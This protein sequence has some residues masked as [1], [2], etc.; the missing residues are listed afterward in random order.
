MASETR[1]PK[2]A[3]LVKGRPAGHIRARPRRMTVAPRVG[4]KT[5]PVRHASHLGGVPAGGAAPMSHTLGDGVIAAALDEIYV[6]DAETLRFVEVSAGAQN[7]LGYG[8]DD[9]RWM[10]PVHIKPMGRD[11]FETMIAP[12]RA[13]ARE[14]LQFET[15]HQRKDGSRYPVQVRLQLV[16]GGERPLFLAVV[17]DL[18]E[19]Q[20]LD[21]LLRGEQQVLE[22]MARNAKANDLLAV[23]IGGIERH[24]PRVRCSVLLLDHEGGRAH[25]VGPRMPAPLVAALNEMDLA[26]RAS[27]C[28]EAVFE[29]GPV[30]VG[31]VA[32]ETRWPVWQQ[33]ARAVGM[34]ACWSVPILAGSD[35]VVGAFS[36]YLEVRAQASR[37]Q[38]GLL[39]RAAHLAAI[40]LEREKAE[41]RMAYLSHFDDLT[42]LPNRALLQERVAKA[43]VHARRYPRNAAVLFI[44]L[45][46]WAQMSSFGSAVEEQALQHAAQ[47]LAAVTRETDTAARV[48]AHVFG[49]L[50]TDLE[51]TPAVL[52]ACHRIADSLMTPLTIGSLEVVLSPRIGIGLYPQDADTPSDLLQ[53]AGVALQQSQAQGGAECQFYRQATNEWVQQR[54]ALEA[55]LRK[56]LLRQELYLE[57]QPKVALASGRISGVEALLRWRHPTRGLVAPAEFIPVAEDSGL[58]VPIGAWVLEAACRQSQRWRAAGLRPLGMAVNLSGRQFGDPDLVWLVKRVLTE[59][60]LD[61]GSLELE[62]TESILMDRVEDNAATLRDIKQ[63]GVRLALDDFGTGY[64]S[65]SHLS[66][67]PVDRLKIDRAFVQNMAQGTGQGAI[68]TAIITMAH[69]L[70]LVVTAEGV[71]TEAQR[72]LLRAQGCDEIQGYLLSRALGPDDCEALLRAHDRAGAESAGT[73]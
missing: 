12:L 37:E 69:A 36:L 3:E 53:C 33:A 35:H 7:N 16:T 21:A 55:D 8:A 59:T 61:P 15:T 14:Q 44:S 18:T 10:T 45:D 43:L 25:R 63:L 49:V 30:I 62:L 29:G 52:S 38:I 19:R 72:Q 17:E 26:A 40:A 9:L 28:A 60:G 20:R 68:A 31:D 2:S 5:R 13:G 42:G 1:G 65:L 4:G 11:A 27:P 46:R 22:Q 24:Y 66:R 58:I 47:R 6:F 41:R 23:I 51:G 57:Y 54:W 70:G 67:F 71:E 34:Q 48:E 39:M 50:L 64:S 56:A 32:L 73:D